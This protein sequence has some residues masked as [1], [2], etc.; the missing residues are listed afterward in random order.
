MA[1]LAKALTPSLASIAFLCLL[2]SCWVTPG[3]RASSA[4]DVFTQ[5]SSAAGIF[6]PEIEAA[7]HGF[8][9]VF[10][11][12]GKKTGDGEFVQ[13]LETNRLYLT[14]TYD[15]GSGH[16]IEEKAVFRQ[17][18]VLAQDEWSWR[19]VKDKA[20]LRHFEVDFHSGQATGEK[21]DGTKVKRWSE[22]F[23]I[24]SAKTFAGIGFTFA[25][26]ALR[27]RL[28]KGEKIELQ[29]VAFT[30]KPR[31]VTIQLSYRGL[32]QIAMAGR[33]VKSDCFIIHP[34]VPA[35]AKLFIDARD[36][37]IWLTANRP[38]AFVRWEGSILEPDDP[39]IRV[40]LLPADHSEPAQPVK[41]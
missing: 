36:T 6:V 2:L 19:E 5:G 1:P 10:D 40:D 7:M 16:F 21:L 9:G 12:L 14:S 4:E 26:K 24:D 3:A 34:E 8:P 32:D 27:E 39:I 29:A 28:I 25:L 23:K 38:A 11:L 20:V 41:N 17:R 33:T 13:W 35:I 15:F 22:S 30:P 18:P 37:Q 31:L